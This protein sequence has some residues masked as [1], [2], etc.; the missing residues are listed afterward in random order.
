MEMFRD[1]SVLVVDDSYTLRISM[2]HMLEN[3]GFRVQLAENARQCLEILEKSIPQAIVLDIIMPEM[4]GI[5]L[6]KIIR[7]R[8]E[9]QTVPILVLTTESDVEKKV[10]AL[11]AGADDFLGKPFQP[12]ELVARLSVRL[13]NK[14]LNDELLEARAKAD[15]MAKKAREANAAKSIFLAIMSHEIRTPMNSVIGFSKLLLD[16]PL[17]DEQTEY[18][19]IIKKS[20]DALLSLIDDILDFSKIES[21]NLKLERIDFDPEMLAHDVCD[22]VRPKIDPKKVEI[23]CRIG[24]NVP[25]SLSGDRFRIHQALVNL[26]GNASKYTE[27][28]EIELA[29]DADAEEGHAILRV[30]V[31]DTGIGIPPDRFETIFMPF[32]Q[33][34]CSITRKYGGTGLGLSICKQIAKKMEGDVRVE[35]PAPVSGSAIESRADDSTGKSEN[36]GCVFYFTA[37]LANSAKPAEEDGSPTLFSGKRVLIVDDNANSLEILKHALEKAKI[38]ATGRTCGTRIEETLAE[39]E[40]NGAPF[41]AIIAD[42]YMPETDGFQVAN[43]VRAMAPPI[44]R[45]P[46][47][48]LSSVME[49]DTKAYE[50]AGFDGFLAKPVRRTKLYKTLAGIFSGQEQDPLFRDRECARVSDAPVVTRFSLSEPNKRDIRILLAEDNPVNQK[51]ATIILEKGG[52]MVETADNGREAYEKYKNDPDGFDIVFMDVQMPRMDGM[53]AA[54][55]IRKFEAE[56]RRDRPVPIVAMTAMAFKGDREKCLEAGMDEYLPK[57]IRRE[58]V[59]GVIKSLVLKTNPPKIYRKP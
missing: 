38:R 32:Q 24:D 48:A 11:N 8:E 34:D 20:G 40:R 13:R 45:T 21:G 37:R 54:A 51:L 2:Q 50:A 58:S 35:S 5:S 17:S 52:C 39:A 29:L 59:F 28:G 27:T 57:P 31:R 42:I 15:L 55:L 10:A 7:S 43:A 56:T 53:E 3:L 19:K 26:M 23:L 25:P 1:I 18:V 36:P 46:L 44:C 12:E 16:T 6:C 22:L 14:G 4:D 9:F 47:I 41:D 30:A 49:S 33:V